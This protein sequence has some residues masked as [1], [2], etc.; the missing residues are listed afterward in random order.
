MTLYAGTVPV[1][2]GAANIQ[3][4]SPTRD[5]GKP[6]FLQVRDFATVEE[7]AARMLFLAS[8]QVEY[9][10]YLEWRSV[11]LEPHF[12]SLIGSGLDLQSTACTLCKHVARVRRR[13]RLSN[14][15]HNM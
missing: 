10:K 14:I 12:V 11:P 3:D 4:M 7:L 2:L 6:S 5:S 13:K 8:N 15:T 9:A 1:Y